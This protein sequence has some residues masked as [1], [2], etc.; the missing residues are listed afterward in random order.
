MKK[1]FII[2]LS[3]GVAL[4]ILAQWKEF[5]YISALLA[6]A[7]IFFSIKK[8]QVSLIDL[9]VLF[10]ITIPLHTLRFGTQEH[11][12]RLSEI[13]FIPLFLWWLAQLSL[14]QPGKPITMRKEFIF[15]IL[16]LLINIVSLKNSIYPG[17]SIER[18]AILA[19]LFLFVYMVIN[20]LDSKDKIATIIKTSILISGF[21]AIIAAFQS[22]FPNLI[23]F[24]A[25]P[26]GRLLGITFYRAGVGW[27]DPNYYALYLGM[28]ASLT[29]TFILSPIT[30]LLDKRLLKICFFLQIIGILS[31]FSRTVFLSLTFVTFYLFYYFGRRRL[32]LSLLSITL[33][34]IIIISVSSLVIYKKNPFFASVLYRVADKDKLKE[35]PTL[36]MG[37]RYAAFKA[38]TAMFLDHPILGVGPFMAM[39]N[40]SEYRPQGYKYPLP[41][42]ASHN[43]YLQLL[44]EKGIFGFLIFLGFIFV[45]LKSMYSFIKKAADPFG[46]TCLIGLKSS[47]FVYLIVSLGLETSYELQ[48]W[49]TMGLAMAVFNMLSKEEKYAL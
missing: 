1:L 30:N 29:L 23:I 24:T 26:M 3:L 42:L 37:H 8:W 14:K 44:S 6:C 11:F 4:P 39:Y 18:I 47:I 49:L 43:Q 35:E 34:T 5:Y 28:N 32:A 38:N 22:I 20:I 40:F 21:S 2:A 27:H 48:F 36:V 16:Y 9:L 10:L 45:I 25:V 12:I 19:Y 7:L 41:W 17:I 33:I 13:A 15:L 31:T 46:K